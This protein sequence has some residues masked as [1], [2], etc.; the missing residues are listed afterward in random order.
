M[1]LLCFGE[2]SS[3]LLYWSELVLVEAK[4]WSLS[5]RRGGRAARERKIAGI[6]NVTL[7]VMELTDVESVV[8][9][10]LKMGCGGV[11]GEGCCVDS[12]CSLR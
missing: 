6:L 3:N 8:G 11:V 12:V 4:G 9:G 7:Y 5:G 1:E 10:R 2:V